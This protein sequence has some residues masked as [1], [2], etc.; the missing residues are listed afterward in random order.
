MN[1]FSVIHRI[2]YIH[3]AQV[4]C[5][6]NFVLY[7]NHLYFLLQKYGYDSLILIVVPERLYQVTDVEA[8]RPR[9]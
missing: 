4:P 7:S 1:T 9:N 6:I 5:V 8:Y 2:A 3:F